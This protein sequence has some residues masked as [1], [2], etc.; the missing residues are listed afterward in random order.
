M[1][2]DMKLTEVSR[3]RFDAESDEPTFVIVI[4]KDHYKRFI[5]DSITTR[6]ETINQAI[7]S[8]YI[9]RNSTLTL[10]RHGR[11]GFA[12]CGKVVELDDEVEL[13][14]KV[15]GRKFI[16]HTALTLSHIQFF[17]NHLRMVDHLPPSTNK[18][19]L[20][21]IDMNCANEPKGH[22]IFGYMYHTMSDWCVDT[23]LTDKA[24]MDDAVLGAM[25]ATWKKCA[26]R[27]A[28]DLRFIVSEDGRP[29][30]TSSDVGGVISNVNY[31]DW[32]D[33]AILPQRISSDNVDSPEHGL[34]LLAGWFKLAEM[35][36]G[37][38][39]DI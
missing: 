24:R 14:I 4:S 34:T 37:D 31:G 38:I 12:R 1:S 20:L 15:R 39:Y 16:R 36:R 29:A 11:F 18:Q 26:G 2:D 13:H 9:G 19:Q 5:K 27:L 30:L 21:E 22:G 17:T 6:A 7:V 3:L 25:L 32:D 35:A 23:L 28:T 8:K 10:D 33:R